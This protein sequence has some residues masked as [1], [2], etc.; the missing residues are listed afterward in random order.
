LL[1]GQ[2]APDAYR[3]RSA[4]LLDALAADGRINEVFGQLDRDRLLGPPPASAT[5]EASDAG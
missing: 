3:E 5:G 2:I 1:Q 4:A